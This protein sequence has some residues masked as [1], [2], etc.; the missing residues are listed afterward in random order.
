MLIALLMVV[1]VLVFGLLGPIGQ[2]FGHAQLISSSPTPDRVLEEPPK[3]VEFRFNEKVSTDLGELRVIGPDGSEL[4]S[5]VPIADSAD[6]SVVSIGVPGD[7][8]PGTYTAI[9]RVVSADSHPISGGLS[10]VVRDRSSSGGSG[11]EANASVPPPPAIDDEPATDTSTEIFFWLMRLIALAATALLVGVLVFLWSA[12]LLR[13][14]SDRAVTASAG[15]VRPSGVYLTVGVVGGVLAVLL[16]IPAQGATAEASSLGSGFDPTTLKAVAET[17]F[18]VAN[19]ARAVGFFAFTPVAF[20]LIRGGIPA[21]PSVVA[22]L[23]GALLLFVSPGQA[24]HAAT[25]D[26]AWII[27]PAS[28]AHTASMAIWGGG[29]I[30]MALLLVRWASSATGGRQR[31]VLET[32]QRFSPVALVCA[33]VLVASGTAQSV[34]EVGSFSALVD[35]A[36]GRLVLA[37]VAIFLVLVVLGWNNRSRLLPLLADLVAKRSGRDSSQSLIR[38]VTAGALLVTLAL[39]VTSALVAEEPEGLAAPPPP[40]GSVSDSGYRMEYAITPGVEGRNEITLRISPGSGRPAPQKVTLAASQEESGAGAIDLGLERRN[41]TTYT[42]PYAVLDRP[43]E[44]SFRAELR[45][46]RFDLEVL[47]FGAEVGPAG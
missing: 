47:E 8:G 14:G 18:G 23:L 12:R 3:R 22:A 39:M 5:G 29:L 15:T 44:W 35:T 34:V 2:A 30:A 7:A 28:I 20:V 37:K 25:A 43:G 31:V 42:S 41:E 36:F 16:M 38:S 11:V 19:L 24:G 21:F 10:F 17:R 6:P 1:P 46:G 32:L 9:Y 4:I 45:T 13:R 33:L 27:V 26:P 40:S